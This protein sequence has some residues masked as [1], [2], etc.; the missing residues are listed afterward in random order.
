MPHHLVILTD[1]TAREQKNQHA[2]TFL[3]WLVASGR[4]QTITNNFFRVGHTHMK[5][6]QRFSVVGSVLASTHLLQ[7]PDEFA[8]HIREHVRHT[9]ISTHIEVTSGAWDWQKLVQQLRSGCVW[10]NASPSQPRGVPLLEIRSEGRPSTIRHSRYHRS[11]GCAR[12]VRVGA[13]Q[14]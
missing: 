11:L 13:F 10:T 9:H 1:S 3:A 2:V 4:F 12:G 5:L 7:T 8:T 6:D 14:P